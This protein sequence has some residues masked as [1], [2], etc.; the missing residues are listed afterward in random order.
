MTYKGIAFVLFS[1]LYC[2]SFIECFQCEHFVT[3]EATYELI[4]KMADK[5][6]MLTACQVLSA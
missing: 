6:L 5:S 4:F 3:F 2:S 1:V